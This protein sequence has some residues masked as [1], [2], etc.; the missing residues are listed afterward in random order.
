M[1][2]TTETAF[3]FVRSTAQGSGGAVAGKMPAAVDAGIEILQA[4][5]NA[6]DAAV[7]TAFAMGVAEPWMNGIGGG[8][9]LVGWLAKEQRAFTIEYPMISPSGA[10][11]DM[12]PLDEGVDTGLFGW[13]R[14]VGNANVFGYRSVAVPGTVA[15]LCLAHERYG[16]LPLEHVMAPAIRLAEEG[17]DVSWHTTLMLAKD[18]GTLQRFPETAAIYLDAKGNPPFVA[19][20]LPTPRIKNLQ[21][22]KTLRAIAEH[23]PSA[24][25][26]GARAEQ[27]ASFLSAGGSPISPDD[28]ES[29]EACEE[30]GISIDIH[31]HT[32]H[33]VGNG[34][35]GTSLVEALGILKHLDPGADGQNS[36]M[37]LHKMVH[38]FRQAFADRFTYLA[39]PA[40]VDVPIATLLDDTYHQERAARFSPE[41][42]A[43]TE[44]GAR[45]RLG[46]THDLA[47]SVPEYMR[48][49]ST[50]H[51][52]VVDADGNAVSITQTLLSLWGSRVTDPET[53]VLFN[54]GMMW[55]DPE[56]GRPNSVGGRKRPLSNMAPA[57]L[58]RD[59]HLVATVGSSGGRKIMNCNAQIL[60]NLAIWGMTMG[61]ALAAPRLDTSTSRLTVS[62]RMDPATVEGLRTLGHPVELVDETLLAGGFASPVGIACGA[63]GVLKAAAD[64]W[65]FPATAKVLP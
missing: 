22:G 52:G 60:L 54:N 13:P 33:T 62:M 21:L 45:S 31:G 39:D 48:D 41:T 61:E 55:F 10:S 3:S 36:P 51:L 32:V 17:V 56:P 37:A 27:M 15:G 6:F 44:A 58:S 8:G 46:V 20:G 23:G 49:G 24:F 30:P 18:L 63:D 4:G 1:S 35:G 14:T 43:Q 28:F 59:G 2:S 5:G 53:G 16:T 64:A 19:E 34:S 42:I 29:Y 50:T 57:I 11:E 40:C 12:F 7:A 26:Q 9:F 65:Y 38:A 25:Y 47:A